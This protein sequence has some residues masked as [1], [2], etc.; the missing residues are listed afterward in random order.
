MQ[1]KTDLLETLIMKNKERLKEYAQKR[2]H[3]EGGNEK[4]K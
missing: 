2:Y 4:G 3:Q 1:E